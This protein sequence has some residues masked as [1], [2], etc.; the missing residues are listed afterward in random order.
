M[1]WWSLLPSYSHQR[2]P[3]LRIIL[4]MCLSVLLKRPRKKSKL[5]RFKRWM[6]ADCKNRNIQGSK[7]WEP[8]YD[9]LCVREET[10]HTEGLRNQCKAGGLCK[11]WSQQPGPNGKWRM[12]QDSRRQ[13]AEAVSLL[14]S[15][16][17]RQK[18]SEDNPSQLKK[19]R[20]GG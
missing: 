20:W 18:Q 5:G 7:Q 17:I 2:T 11:V 3:K 16:W 9:E 13:Q 19:P 14:L 4:L 12:W 1:G 6:V 15:F 8:N 10:E